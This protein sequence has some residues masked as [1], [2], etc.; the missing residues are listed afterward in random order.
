MKK[1][2]MELCDLLAEDSTVL[3]HGLSLL[4]SQCPSLESFSDAAFRPTVRQL[5]G[6]LAAARY[7][8]RSKEP[9]NL[10]GLL[11]LVLQ[12]VA[13]IPSISRNEAW[14][15]LFVS[16]VF[17]GYFRE[18]LEYLGEVAVKRPSVLSSVSNA[19]TDFVLGITEEGE[20]E[21]GEGA[22][23]WM[24]YP[25]VR[26]FVAAL[27]ANFA[28]LDAADAESL[29][30]CIL[31][32]WLLL[33]SVAIE[34]SARSASSQS[35]STQSSPIRLFF[36]SSSS[37]NGKSSSMKDLRMA[38]GYMSD[39][40]TDR[41][42]TSADDSPKYD[43]NTFFTPNSTPRGTPGREPDMAGSFLHAN[44]NGNGN[45]H[46]ST[47]SEYVDNHDANK[48]TRQLFSALEGESIA[49]LE[50][51]ELG[52]RLFVQIL[53]KIEV[54]EQLV[55]QL[56]IMAV[57]QLGALVPLL[58]IRKREWPV[59][60]VPL[61]AKMNMKL[62]ASQAAATVMTIVLK[63]ES[64]LR[65]SR[66]PT[67]RRSSKSP[68]Q[69]IV[70]L[71][72]DT[73]DACMASP[74]R[75]MK[76]CECL[77]G[78][79]L[80]GVS[81]S[82]SS[83]GNQI[84]R[85]LLLRIKT[86]VLATCSQADTLA[87]HQGPVFESVTKASCNLIEASW[88]VDRAA[89]ES[90]LLSLAAYVRERLE[91][92]KKF[93]QTAVVTQ[94]NVIPLLANVV[95]LLN[96]TE[97]VELIMPLFVESLAEGDASAPSLMRLKVL[98]AVA[99]MA[100]L[101]CEKPYRE[102]VV[103]LTMSYLKKLAAIGSPES[104][105]LAPEATT[106]LLQTLPLAFLHI[107]QGLK[108]PDLRYDYRQRL[109]NLCCDVS[110]I[111]ESKIGRNGAEYLGPLLPAVAEICSDLE[112]THEVD[113]SMQKLFRNLWF[114]IVLYGLAPP[115]HKTQQQN[116][117]SMSSSRSISSSNRGRLNINQTI[118]G[119]YNWNEEWLSAV[120]RLTQSTPPLV[121]TSLKWL[122][123]EAELV[124]L[125]NTKNKQGTGNERSSS[126]QR[127]LLS[128]AIGGRLSAGSLSNLSGV[129]ATYLLAVAFLEILRFS[130]RGGVIRK[131]S[132]DLE[133]T[134]LL[135]CVFK[136]LESPNLPNDLHQCLTA[137]VHCAFDAA[138][139]WLEKRVATSGV[140]VVDKEKVLVSHACFLIKLGTHREEAVREL[141]DS[142]L[143][144]LRDRF[145]Q[146][147]WKG[148][149]LEALLR[150]LSE[151]PGARPG[152][153]RS[154][155]TPRSTMNH[156]RQRVK[157]WL[158]HA[159]FFA[160][161]TTQGLLQE[162]IR[163]VGSWQ[164]VAAL[165]SEI[166]CESCNSFMEN[167]P[168][169]IAAAA[170][171]TGDGMSSANVK[172]V[173]L[174]SMKRLL[175][176]SL[177]GLP[178]TNG[179]RS[180]GIHSN[181][182]LTQSGYQKK[183]NDS[184]E[185]TAAVALLTS[186]FVQQM[187]QYLINSQIGQ[188]VDSEQFKATCLQASALLLSDT[189]VAADALPEGASQ[190]LRLLCWCPAQIFT[191]EV[192]ETGVFVWTWLLAAAPQLGSLVLSELVDAWLWTVAS[193]RGLFAGGID[194]SGPAAELRPHLT[195]GVPNPPPA[196]DP[197]EGIL[198]H[199]LWLGF[200]VDRFEVVKY[201]G[202]DQLLLITRL[203]Q[204]SMQ[205]SSHFSSHP[206]AAGSFFTLLLLGLKLCDCLREN[207]YCT[208]TFGASLLQDRIHRAAFAWF[209]VE[210]G[211]YKM[212]VPGMAKEEAQAV[213]IFAHYLAQDSPVSVCNGEGSS[214]SKRSSRSGSQTLPRS[215]SQPQVNDH[216]V[217]GKSNSDS[218]ATERKK[219]LWV[220][221]QHEADRLETW[222]YPLRENL[223]LRFKPSSEA[224]GVHVKTAWAV[225]PR[226]ALALVAR[227]PG[228]LSVRTEVAS[229]VQAHIPDLINV[230]E[231]LRY[232]VTPT[233]V[234]E[235]SEA[236]NWLPH[237]APCSITHALEF[238]TPPYKGHP[239][240]MAY[241]LR[242][243][244]SY[245]P[246]RVTFFMP[247]L[248]QALR[249]DHGGLVEGYLMVAA[250]RSNLF[251]HIL[252][253]QL[254]G[255]EAPPLDEAG[256]EGVNM[257]NPL[258]EIVPKVK[259]RIIDSFTAEA[260][261]IYDQEF[262]F[263]DKVTSISGVLFP[264]PKESRRQAIRRELEKIEVEGD[265][266]YLPTDPTKLVKG[267]ELDSGIPLQSAAKVPIMITFDVVDKEGDQD[268]LIRQA[269]IFKVGDD[270]RQDVLA[271][272]VIALLKEIWA[273]IG[274]DLY[275]FPYGVL[276]TGYGRGIIEV[277][278]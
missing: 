6:I 88:D 10:D 202:S 135:T 52:F 17:D 201:T 86:L 84:L 227:F 54:N 261:T 138:L 115:I 250:H 55:S 102:V 190:L 58:K 147:L 273:A 265:A 37:S 275:L 214:H 254:Q 196:R 258:Y 278:C 98:E 21:S 168:A 59:D 36:S 205:T 175:D 225:N 93:K 235:D 271:L 49:A 87:G 43:T 222:A 109:L 130:H 229:M 92:E 122:E 63:S 9:E 260:F 40:A 67:D 90:F 154:N 8:A 174:V 127:G 178:L 68:T 20:D 1:A 13:T 129:K 228:A 213:A 18:L 126:V 117:H 65:P 171:A 83:Q 159:L 91:Q 211:W 137:I 264:L 230:P 133:Y 29:A 74:W 224:W 221:C 170:A 33:P 157:E 252:I 99:R 189:G 220:L 16:E 113:S 94:L 169:V 97:A 41:L 173:E 96:R 160:P 243:M 274:L 218:A 136:Y 166:E 85:I 253:W 153:N 180:N 28:A 249:Y 193:R 216:P 195:A 12:F 192:M 104:R 139:T 233:A 172:S 78:T 44:G 66:S 152:D 226:I 209:S 72:L 234:K 256:K 125:Y 212:G 15:G 150:L 69:E 248:V 3:S 236:L 215:T 270:C 188:P 100:C 14:P 266:L 34:S 145:P 22:V 61:L 2:L 163:R 184:K 204:G 7:L 217:W 149:C 198:A 251:A 4:W 146:V 123:D 116:G 199:R 5:D 71:L 106:E 164:K 57:S 268:Q 31:R 151:Q 179:S 23:R 238:L 128:A 76:S 82:C 267:I 208:G 108:G 240:V 237:W 206:A 80:S 183:S 107:A 35:L 79:L 231:A 64:E 200:L 75:R 53:E 242:V 155:L 186:R 11:A 244:E 105:N 259:K 120:K 27:A 24:R 101:G 255:E 70:A 262:Q 219:L 95:V 114:Y 131:D 143:I 263:F 39:G 77:F 207:G 176:G 165:L 118:S 38:Q 25:A 161:C 185:K 182:I 187:Q 121:V 245:P 30:N 124:A 81:K 46:R 110:S 103:L 42:S 181:G 203:M 148:Q 19:L 210:P 60:G 144:Q 140:E 239:R 197:V 112:P 167:V 134:S 73:A 246:E 241:V 158:T 232:V 26:S 272:Q 56:R 48:R 141:A 177:S 51:Q 162:Y 32:D 45:G 89:I 257:K 276:P 142:L 62:Q 119:A 47:G 111:V 132:G 223:Q 156:I 277:H 269:C 191:V 247:Q 194:N 50:R